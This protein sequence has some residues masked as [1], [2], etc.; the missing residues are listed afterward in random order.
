[1]IFFAALCF[2]LW[3]NLPWILLNVGLRVK[4]SNFDNSKEND[5]L[6]P[7]RRAVTTVRKNLTQS[8]NFPLGG[9]GRL[10]EEEFLWCEFPSGGWREID[11]G[12]VLMMWI[13]PI[14]KMVAIFVLFI[15]IMFQQLLYIIVLWLYHE[16]WLKKM[17]FHNMY[18][19]TCI[20][21]S[22]PPN[23]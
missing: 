14:L 15:S 12:G 22:V 10:T 17:G 11:R 20:F 13:S 2:A 4:S 3:C 5:G 18:L 19:Y 7:I 21:V 1:M 8:V 9:G 23:S 16:K 6:A